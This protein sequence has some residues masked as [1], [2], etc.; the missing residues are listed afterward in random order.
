MSFYLTWIYK[1]GHRGSFIFQP[2][3]LLPNKFEANIQKLEGY[4]LFL[5]VLVDV[6]LLRMD[7][8]K[9]TS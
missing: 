5:F 3:T 4:F 1:K 2:S 6:I 8:Q 7:L 9:R